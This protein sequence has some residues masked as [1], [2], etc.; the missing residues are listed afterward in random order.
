[1][2]S[3]QRRVKIVRQTYSLFLESSSVALQASTDLE[4]F[5]VVTMVRRLAAQEHSVAL[6]QLA[7]RISANMKFGVGADDHPAASLRSGSTDSVNITRTDFVHELHSA[8]RS[9]CGGGF[10][11]LTDG[12]K[13]LYHG[14]ENSIWQHRWIDLDKSSPMAARLFITAW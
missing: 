9:K 4:R 12:S 3:T 2:S 8:R 6:A 13:T 11:Q 14:M 10:D 1:M 5:E 7:S